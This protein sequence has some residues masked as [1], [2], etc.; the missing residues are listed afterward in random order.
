MSC[1]TAIV[2][3]SKSSRKHLGKVIKD[4]LDNAISITG[5]ESLSVEIPD[6][7]KMPNIISKAIEDYRQCPLSKGH[8]YH[9]WIV[10]KS[11]ES[12][13]FLEK[14]FKRLS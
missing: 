1:I 10:A 5:N 8:L 7:I 14:Y 6:N 4:V 3:V 2:F 12:L 11:K 9:I 13:L